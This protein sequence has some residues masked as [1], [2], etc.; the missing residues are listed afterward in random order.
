MVL[1]ASMIASQA[2]AVS[3]DAGCGSHGRGDAG[4][5]QGPFP[6]TG[7][8]VVSGPHD[9]DLAFGVERVTGIEPA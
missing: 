8:I 9:A 4:G 6:I 1:L 3:G 5:G 2:L 7:R